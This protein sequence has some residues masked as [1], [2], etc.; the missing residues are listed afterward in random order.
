MLKGDIDERY[1]GDDLK[2]Q[3][4]LINILGN[5]VKFL[6][7]DGKV[8]LLIEQ[9]GRNGDN[10]KL[11][12]AI[13]DTGDG[14]EE[15]FL[16][17]IFEAFTK[18]NSG[19]TSVYGGSGLG[20]AISKNLVRLMDGNID[21]HSEK[22]IG[23]AFMVAVKLGLPA[24]SMQRLQFETIALSFLKTLIVADD[25][26]DCQNAEIVLKQAGIA[27][28][29]IDSSAGSRKTGGRAPCQTR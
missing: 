16:P 26:I 7:K 4:V 11:C 29:W 27:A 25:V 23:S 2:L 6:P 18:E 8:Q 19:M 14:I 22:D 3:Q 10:A 15:N 17:H 21:A 13:R 24:E 12:F 5:A 28:E 1:V 20:L 9:V